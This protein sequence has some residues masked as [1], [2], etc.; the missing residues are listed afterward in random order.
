MVKPVNKRMT[1]K[2]EM[3]INSLQNARVKN[4]VRLRDGRHRQKQDRFLVDGIR[5][6]SRANRGGIEIVEVFVCREICT[7]EQQQRLEEV[8]NQ[9]RQD[10][11]TS[12]RGAWNLF[13]VSKNVFHKMAFGD[14]AEG[15]LAVAQVPH[16]ELE[17]LKLPEKPLVAVI[18]GIEKPGNIGAVIRSADAAAIDA[19]ILADCRTDLFNPN[20]I[21]ASLGTVL[22][23]P[24]RETSTPA[25]LTW[26]RAQGLPIFT[27]RVD[28]SVPY[29]EIDFRC[30]GAIVLGSEADGL[31]DEWSGDDIQAV[32]LPMLGVADSLNISA[33]AAVL[34][35][36]ALRQREQT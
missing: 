16:W 4:V 1:G 6:L 2:P 24:I 11:G 19:V 27:A 23:L 7:E 3:E 15:V 17:D 28:G 25:S 12:T 9:L 34:F 22:T 31:T 5:E 20:A 33:T 13:Q 36:E 30:G 10:K 26:L 21:R 8:L 18:E 29:T 32:R 14:R 35:F